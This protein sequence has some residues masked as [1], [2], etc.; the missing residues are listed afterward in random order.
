MK[1]FVECELWRK[2][3]VLGESLPQ[4]HFFQHKSHMT[5]DG[6]RAVAV[7]SRRLSQYSMA[8]LLFFEELNTKL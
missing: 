7:G 6:T 4:Y 1:Q 3:E 2:A 5:C 8:Q